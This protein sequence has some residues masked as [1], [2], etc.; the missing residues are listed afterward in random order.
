[1]LKLKKPITFK[2]I[3]EKTFWLARCCKC[4]EY[5]GF[6]D[7]MFTVFESKAEAKDIIESDDFWS[8]KNG[9]V[10]CGECK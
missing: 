10:Y 6:D 5:Y 9:K 7:N 3:E 1:M 2:S 8:I 4:G